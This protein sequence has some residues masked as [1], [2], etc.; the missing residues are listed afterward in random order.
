MTDLFQKLLEV[1][2]SNPQHDSGLYCQQLLDLHQF[3]YIT[4][5][6]PH[7]YE[8]TYFPM[9]VDCVIQAPLW[10]KIKPHLEEN[11][12]SYQVLNFKTGCKTVHSLLDTHKRKL[13]FEMLGKWWFF[14]DAPIPSFALPEAV[15]FR[16][17]FFRQ[18]FS[19]LPEKFRKLTNEMDFN[20]AIHMLTEEEH[21]FLD[22][23]IERLKT[24]HALCGCIQLKKSSFCMRL[25]EP[26][27]D[28][29]PDLEL[30]DAD[31]KETYNKFCQGEFLYLVITNYYDCI[32]R[33][34][35]KKLL[36]IFTTCTQ[37]EENV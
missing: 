9:F 5:S 33:G 12:I 4:E 1:G 17:Q 21:F 8:P 28:H 26:E 27:W 31:K 14:Q 20:T 35:Y 2:R 22:D 11:Y 34:L 13:L 25:E 10:F 16:N 6:T 19:Y 30:E 36:E 37:K 24:P 32:D 3:I 23:M 15:A 29:I 18:K 7:V